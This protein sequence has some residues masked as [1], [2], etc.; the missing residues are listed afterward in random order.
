LIKVIAFDLFGT[1]FDL[2]GVDRAEIR[3]YVK[4]VH[5][6]QWSELTL[7]DSWLSMPLFSD[8]AEGLKRLRTRFKVITLSNAPAI[9]QWRLNVGDHFDEICALDKH[10]VYKP[11][12]RAYM[13]ACVE[14][15]VEPNELMMVTANKDFGDLEA[16][17]ALGMTPM[18]IR[19][20]DGPKTII[21]LAEQLG[22]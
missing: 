21:E 17:A 1:V 13:A 11:K 20:G 22:C 9:F 15:M 7:P 10:M 2:S 12:P 8:S 19:N 18:L 3:D 14:Q 16:S 6:P 4:H 5:E